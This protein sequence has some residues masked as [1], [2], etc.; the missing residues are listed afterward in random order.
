[1]RYHFMHQYEP[2]TL[3]SMEQNAPIF[4]DVGY[5]SVLYP[6]ATFTADN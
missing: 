6:F 1:M 4:D 3:E 5:C 2:N